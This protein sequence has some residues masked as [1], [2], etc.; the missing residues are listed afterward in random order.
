ML[1]H[2]SRPIARIGAHAA[3]LIAATVAAPWTAAAQTPARPA[4]PSAAA[5]LAQ[6]SS[7]LRDLVDRY[8]ADRAALLRRYDTPWSPERR[9]RLASFY[10]A[11]QQQLATLPFEPLDQEGRVDYILLDNQLRYE[12]VLLAREE[13]LWAE[14]TPVAP[15]AARVIALQEARRR[16]EPVDPQR[17]A[18]LLADLATEIDRARASID[19]S[20]SASRAARRP[21][22]IVAFR[23]AE[24]LGGVQRTLHAWYGYY[25]G[26]D[27][28]FT[29]WAAEPYRRADASLAAYTRALRE[30]VVGYREG[31]DPP[32][33]GDPI[34]ADGL[35]ADLAHEMI[36]YTPAELIAIGERELAWCEAEMRKA[37]RE[38]GFGDDWHRALEQV[39]NG[40][41]PPGK[42]TD[43]VRDLAREA[44]AFVTS[45]DLVTVP[46]LADEIWRME[47]MSPE[48]QK[49]NPFFL[50][51]EEIIVSYPTDGMT[52]EDKMMSMRGNNPNF[53]RATVHHEL[54]PGHH[55]QAFM[56]ERY[57]PHRRIFETPFW[58]EG[59]SLYWE[60]RLWDLGFPTTP[61]QR[62]GMLFWRMHRAARIIFSLSFHLG[63][64]TPEQAIDFLV[65]RVGHERANATAE[66]RRSF[67]G[68]YSPLYQAG[69]ML[70]GL[71]QRA[72]WHELVE[73]RKMT[74]RQ[75]H[76][77]ILQGGPMPIELAR[78]RLEHTPLAR[79]YVARWKF[80]GDAPFAR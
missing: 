46:P 54:I 62:V 24:M 4:V 67:N 8:A 2:P 76:D 59:N 73:T 41:V 45:R 18:R 77:A 16:F 42:Q 6:P 58:H 10:A 27:P 71:Q 55:L 28:L 63:R 48:A 35:A 69:Y 34:G 12:R 20:P 29:W 23:T 79:G 49:V 5:L 61:E 32:I 70:G 19:S 78:A 11:W 14:M 25:S 68:S 9:A 40:Y 1:A 36:P 33:V 56:N 50:G 38:M 39:K 26:Y 7:P 47:M 57:Q 44:V 51:G 22:R 66:V 80:E 75:F 3:L 72:L 17:T 31:E 37:S 13:T 60:M 30:K 74:E 64:M 21:S 52:H 65:E 43:L 15:F 53:S